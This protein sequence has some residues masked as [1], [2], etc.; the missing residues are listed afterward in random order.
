MDATAL[1]EAVARRAGVQYITEWIEGLGGRVEEAGEYATAALVIG[2]EKASIAAG[3][4]AS[5]ETV[6]KPARLRG[7]FRGLD[8]QVRPDPTTYGLWTAAKSPYEEEKVDEGARVEKAKWVMLFPCYRGDP[9]E[10]VEVWGPR[11]GGPNR[12][13]IPWRFVGVGA[14]E[15]TGLLK[16]VKLGEGQWW[17]AGI[18]PGAFPMLKHWNNTQDTEPWLYGR[19]WGAVCSGSLK[20]ITQA[21][22]NEPSF[23]FI[24]T[25][26]FNQMVEEVEEIP[27]EAAEVFWNTL[28]GERI[29]E[30]RAAAGAEQ[31]KQTVGL[32]EERTKT[33]A[34]TL[35]R[36]YEDALKRAEEA[37]KKF[38]DLIAG[39]KEVAG[40]DLEA[41]LT[42][43]L[44][45]GL[46]QEV[47]FKG[48][49]V[50]LLM[51]DIHGAISPEMVRLY[52]Q[53]ARTRP[54]LYRINPVVLRLPRTGM[55]S[56]FGISTPEDTTHQHHHASA[57]GAN[58]P[59]CFGNV[60]MHP[61]MTNPELFQALWSRG[62]V[63]WVEA[64]RAFMGQTN[65][66]GGY[67]GI[68]RCGTFVA[69]PPEDLPEP[70]VGKLVVTVV[71]QPGLVLEQ[72]HDGDGGRLE[73]E[74]GDEDD[75]Q[76]DEEE[77]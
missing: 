49:D 57:G 50:Y 30:T 15:P 47:R 10:D 61:T 45:M 4:A 36:G 48:A 31:W 23:A 8:A 7:E 52:G 44:E 59:P 34:N 29:A 41:E 73:D 46:V 54:G 55:G 65:L 62:L 64:V 60:G 37:T 26:L 56:D 35:K 40:W 38:A 76:A 39:T 58:A 25:E 6:M 43:V 19:K 24:V 67:S 22:A 72:D 42:K 16:R 13:R 12:V 9:W 33:Q 21:I 77:A 1:R 2:L 3:L 63:P 68:D 11:G 71:K 28:D 14:A 5:D 18:T 74:D 27:E 70:M 75:D 69:P 66:A 51:N 20:G 32:I 17:N 53:L